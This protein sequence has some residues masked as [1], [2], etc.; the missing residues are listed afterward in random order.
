MLDLAYIR[1]HK[2]E[3]KEADVVAEGAEEVIVGG[4]FADGVVCVV[5][6]IIDL[7]VSY[8]EL[9]LFFFLY[10]YKERRIERARNRKQRDQL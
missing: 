5:V 10:I 2:D 7:F 3:V 8:F 4:C 6:F 9:S 1:E